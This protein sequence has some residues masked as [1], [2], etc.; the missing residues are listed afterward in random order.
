MSRAEI[1]RILRLDDRGMAL[2]ALHHILK[3]E[4][5]N[6]RLRA[7]LSSPTRPIEG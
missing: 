1:K 2:W 7:A 3:L 5:E 6:R 4:K